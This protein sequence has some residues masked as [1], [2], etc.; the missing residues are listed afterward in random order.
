MMTFP[1]IGL[2]DQV[3]NVLLTKARRSDVTELPNYYDILYAFHTLRG[4]YRQGTQVKFRLVLARALTNVS[5]CSCLRD[6]RVLTEGRRR[7]SF[8]RCRGLATTSTFSRARC[9]VCEY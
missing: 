8:S 2:V 7:V 4:N 5:F 9:V 3:H 6:L 1:F